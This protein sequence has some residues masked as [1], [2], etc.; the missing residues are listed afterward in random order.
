MRLMTNVP[1]SDDTLA[2]VDVIYSRHGFKTATW[3]GHSLGSLV[4]SWMCQRRKQRVASA[5]LIDPV[6]S[7]WGVMVAD[8]VNRMLMLAV[9][10]LCCGR[11]T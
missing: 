4:V 7:P 8:F 5:V 6:V 10:C 1:T 3:M 11:A 9:R 2:G